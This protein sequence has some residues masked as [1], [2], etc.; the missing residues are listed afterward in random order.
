MFKLIGFL[1]T[2]CW[3]NWEIASVGRLTSGVAVGQ[4]VTS[5]CTKCGKY[6]IQNLI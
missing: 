6:K 3:H 4:R 1:F 2:G 5:K